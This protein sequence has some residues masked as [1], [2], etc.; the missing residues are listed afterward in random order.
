PSEPQAA[1]EVSSS[2]EVICRREPPPTGSRIGARNICKTEVEWARI[3]REARDALED[4]GNR[5]R[6]MNEGA[7]TGC[8]V[9]RTGC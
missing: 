2:M 9:M 4:A 6:M 5:N 8:G 3:E 1:D 7:G